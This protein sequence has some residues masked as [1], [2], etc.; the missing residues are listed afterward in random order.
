MKN[1]PLILSTIILIAFNLLCVGQTNRYKEQFKGFEKCADSLKKIQQFN[2]AIKVRLEIDR[3]DCSYTSNLYELSALYSLTRKNDSAFLYLT[4]A[5]V[6][7]STIDFLVNPDFIFICKDER[8]IDIQN[9]QIEKFEDHNGKFKNLMLAKMLWD[10]KMKDQSYYVF[11]DYTKQEQ[12]KRYW[13]IKDS[14]NRIN[15]FELDSIIQ[16]NGW[17]KLSEVGKD[18]SSSAFLIIQHS[19]YATQKKNFPYLKKAVREDE[20]YPKNLALL[21]DRI[22]LHEKKKQIYGSQ[23]DW[24]PITQKEFFNYETLRNPSKV[25]KRR[26]KVGLGPIEEYVKIWDIT[27]DYRKK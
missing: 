14:I 11:M 17:P 22:R 6:Q 20:A 7:D 24:D 26:K 27:W 2:I 21:T 10:M 5:T 15:L 23:I 8:W 19:E 13:Q 25:N 12:V 3:K 1:S 16:N 4:K 9:S 18:G